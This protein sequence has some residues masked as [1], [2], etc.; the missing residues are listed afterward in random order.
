MN[1]VLEDGVGKKLKEAFASFRQEPFERFVVKLRRTRAQELRKLLSDPDSIDLD[2]F[3]RE[4]WVLERHTSLPD[5]DAK[6]ILTGKVD[7][8]LEKIRQMEKALEAG[9]LKLH[10][11]YIWGT[12]ANIYGTKLGVDEEQKT[13]YVR[14][15]LRVLNETA[16]TPLEKA[17]QIDEI[18][19][20]GPNIATGLV[21]VFHPTEFAIYNG[22]SKGALQELGY[23]VGTLELFQ[24]VAS[25][26]KDKLEAEDFIELDWF[27]YQISQNKIDLNP[28]PRAWWV[29]QGKTYEQQRDGGYLWAPKAS[30]D[31]KALEHWTNLT[32]LR[33]DDVVLH[34]V[35]G[36]VKAASRVVERAV[37][38][39]RPAEL[40][41]DPWNSDGYLVRVTYQ[42]L[43]KPLPLEEIPQDWRIQEGGPFNQHGSPKQTYLSRLSNG[44][45]RRLLDRFA[46]VLPDL[47]HAL[48]STWCIYV[49]H[50]A[51]ENFAI[52]RN[53]QI[54]GT[55]QE[56]RFGGIEEGDSLL[57]VHDLSSDV[58][59][60]PKGFP[61]VG[62]EKFRG[63]A[64]WLLK[65]TATSSVFQDTSP[66][67]PDKTYPYRFRFE[68]TEALQDANF[69]AEEYAPEVADA[70]RRSACSQGRPVLAR[71]EVRMKQDSSSDRGPL[72]VILYGPP[73]TGKTYSVQRRA[74]EIVDPSA[75]SLSPAQAA[76]AF[77]EYRKQG[78][79]EFVT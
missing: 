50:S 79:I 1:A 23:E 4:V 61:C 49:P 73:G 39:P 31:G 2:E 33:P 70:V 34:Y 47:L 22:P 71:G 28:R 66:I 14:Q 63:K 10:G 16:L 55:D 54:W 42:E 13:E 3:N 78:R 59:P 35:K 8:S 9:E 6:K 43:Q 7:V 30:A 69:N 45:V 26:L 15:A 75:K 19:G 44:F 77:R 62:L 17:R 48:R 60:P 29:N 46:E 65:G 32:L 5:G 21:M 27:L 11:N 37:E 57:F 58:A 12:G 67:W 64:K 51:A 56:H 40:S 74:V 24:Q 18:P 52:A 36:T 38:A 76:E 41:G 68:E 25:E 53:E 72:N 20:F